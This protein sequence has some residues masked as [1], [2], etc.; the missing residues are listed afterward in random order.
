SVPLYI[1]LVDLYLKNK[2]TDDAVGVMQKLIVMEPDAAE[3]RLALAGIYW[4]E[5]KEQQAADVLKVFL[6]AGPDKEQRWIQVANF[7]ASKNRPTEAE[8][9]LK[10]GIRQNQKSFQIRFALSAFY[11]L[12]GRQ[13]QGVAVLQECLKLEKDADNPN[14]IHTKNSLA[15]FYLSRN[16]I[17]KAKKYVDEVMKESPKNVDANYI[18]GNIYLRKHE[19][20]Q[21]VSSFRTVVNERPQLIPGYIS[22]AEAHAINKEMDLAF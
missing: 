7:Y 10:E 2:Q 21:A 1:A 13:D 15:Q 3:H 17:D 4:D 19:G 9:Q 20:L 11:L 6:S 14:I 22:L 16:E 5:G 8:Q 18:E 12:T